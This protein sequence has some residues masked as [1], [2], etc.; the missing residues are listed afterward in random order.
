MRTLPAC[1]P[2]SPAS[3]VKIA[4]EFV[5]APR[6][7]RD[8]PRDGL[9]EIAHGRAFECRQIEPDQRAACAS[10]SRARARRPA[11]RGWRTSIASRAGA[12]A[13][14]YLVDLPGYGYARGGASRRS[15]F[16]ELTRAYFEAGRAEAAG[17]RDEPAALLLVDAQAPGPR[18]RP[19]RRG[20]GCRRRSLDGGGRGHEDR[21]ARAR[22][23]DPRAERTRIRV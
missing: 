2:A 6:A 11:R 13:P 5:T 15:E 22:R 20:S 21:Q 9:P 1:Q 7:R 4:A 14:F 18:Q 3:P 19:C 10:A 12:A 17:R 16:E 8:F 23:T